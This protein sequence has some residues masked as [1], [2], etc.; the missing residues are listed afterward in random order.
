MIPQPKSMWQRLKFV[1]AFV[2]FNLTV[3]IQFIKIQR[4]STTSV[5]LLD[6]YKAIDNV[7]LMSCVLQCHND[8]NCV[9]VNYKTATETCE[10]NDKSSEYGVV[11]LVTEQNW[12]V[13]NIVQGKAEVIDPSAG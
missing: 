13:Y 2:N 6:H 8:Q 5:H 4:H 1:I 9:A 11:D 12:D 3:S 10:L 7:P